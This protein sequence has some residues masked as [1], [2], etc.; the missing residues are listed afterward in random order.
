MMADVRARIVAALRNTPDLTAH[1]YIDTDG[2]FSTKL[3]SRDE[4]A[5]RAA[6]AILAAPGVTT[7]A[8][9][10]PTGINGQDNR[11][12]RIPGFYVEQEFNGDVVIN[13]RLAVC[14][15]ELPAL[16]AALAAAAEAANR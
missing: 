2:E 11:V 10:E 16:V 4:V 14:A 15:D 5:E 1:R 6:D 12:W 9:P 7:I 8:L 13:D 3:H